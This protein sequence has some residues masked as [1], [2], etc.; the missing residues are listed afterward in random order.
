MTCERCGRTCSGELRGASLVC[1]RPKSGVTFTPS[2]EVPTLNAPTNTRIQDYPI[3][4]QCWLLGTTTP[5][6]VHV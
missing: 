1:D 2:G 6:P 3:C 4:A 5:R